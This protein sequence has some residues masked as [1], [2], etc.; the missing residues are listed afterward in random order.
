MVAHPSMTSELDTGLSHDE[1]AALKY[2]ALAGALDSPIEVSTEELADR[3]D[4]SLGTAQRSLHQLRDAGHLARRGDDES[5][6]LDI[7]H[8]GHTVLACEYVDYYRLFGPV[9]PLRLTG[10]VTEGVGEASEFV[11][12]AGYAEQFRDR[13]GYEPFHGTLNVVVDDEDKANSHRLA[14]LD[15]VRIDGWESD[16]HTYG[17]VTCYPACIETEDE[18]EYDSAHILVP[19]R[20]QHNASEL[21]ILAPDRLRDE[22]DLWNG[23][24]VTVHV[25]K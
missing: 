8:N 2:V 21:E 17:G 13:L 11:S 19:D 12:L 6:R 3:L 20:T 1:L 23:V 4:V 22:L 14:A 5:K 10:E 16:G 24:R 25:P 9:C 15:G 18:R 7:T